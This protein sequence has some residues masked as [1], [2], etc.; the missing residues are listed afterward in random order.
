MEHKLQNKRMLHIQHYFIACY[1]VRSCLISAEE[2]T[3][4]K[5]EGNLKR[6]IYLPNLPIY[7]LLYT[8]QQ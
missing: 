1:R 6:F 2:S 8:H 3:N 7:Y 4:G 5:F